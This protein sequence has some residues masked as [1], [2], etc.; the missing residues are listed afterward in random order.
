[1]Y[2]SDRGLEELVER[3]GPETVTFAAVADRMQSF[4]DLH[5]DFEA[6]VEQLA[7]FLARDDEDWD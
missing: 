7:V 5:P 3:R 6:A 2:N 4:V 1:M